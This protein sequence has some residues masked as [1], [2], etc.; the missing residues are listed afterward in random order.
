MSHLRRWR[1]PLGGWREHGIIIPCFIRSRFA[2]V[3][4][5]V[6]RRASELICFIFCPLNIYLTC[7]LVFFHCLRANIPVISRRSNFLIKSSV[8]V[9]GERK[10]KKKK[11][12]RNCVSSLDDE[13]KTKQLRRGIIKTFCVSI[14]S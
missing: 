3:Y 2:K 9:D 11:K 6:T 12:T 7:T 8:R 1:V 5:R 10:E 13:E 4:A 14:F